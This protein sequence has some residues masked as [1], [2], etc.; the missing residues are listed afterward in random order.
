LRLMAVEHRRPLRH[1]QRLQLLMYGS[2]R[3]RAF[4]GTGA[5]REIGRWEV[6]GRVFLSGRAVVRMRVDVRAASPS[7]RRRRL[8]GGLV[9]LV[10]HCVWVVLGASGGWREHSDGNSSST[11]VDWT[12]TFGLGRRQWE[13]TMQRAIGGSVGA[14]NNPARWRSGLGA[15]WLKR[16]GQAAGFLDRDGDKRSRRM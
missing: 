12:G 15:V 9:F 10:G 8:E 14:T 1:D 3:H 4:K 2:L 7:H 6:E 5:E 13:Q 16:Q 11:G